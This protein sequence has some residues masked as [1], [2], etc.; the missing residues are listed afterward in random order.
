MS[1]LL[2]GVNEVLKRV[3]IIDSDGGTLASLTDSA[4]QVWIDAAIQCWNEAIDD[5]F[6]SIH[7][8]LPTRFAESS[9][10]LATGDRDYAL[11]SAARIFFPFRE[12]T[13]GHRIE[14]YKAGYQNMVAGQLVPGNY[15]GRALFACIRPTDGQLYL[16]RIPTASENGLVY[17][18]GY[19]T[20]TGLSVA[21]DTMPFSESCFRAMVP[22]VAQLWSREQQRQFDPALYTASLGRAAKFVRRLPPREMWTPDRV[23]SGGSA[24]FLNPFGDE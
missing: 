24:N 20:D 4:R 13:N 18:Y 8:P 14:E 17:V 23:Y 19:E 3:A 16:E 12:N 10:T 11:Q 9:I 15:T 21:A 1:T 7:Q 22:V 2:D 6:S 5:L